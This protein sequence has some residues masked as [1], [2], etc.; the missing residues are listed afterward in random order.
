MC[1]KVRNYE[2]LSHFLETNLVQIY[3]LEHL[4]DKEKVITM[5]F[6]IIF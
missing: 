4:T 2:E 5:Y 1:K 3:N 6:I